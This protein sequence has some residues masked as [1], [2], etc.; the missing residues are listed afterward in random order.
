MARIWEERHRR[1]K[2]DTA[3]LRK[4][5][6]ALREA[7]SKLDQ[8]VKDLYESF[9]LGE[10]SKAEYIAAKAATIQKRDA[11]SKQLAEWVA[12]L[13]NISEDGKLDNQFVARFRPH[14]EAEIEEI[15][16][17]ILSDILREVHVYPGGR[18]EIIW[19]YREE[20]TKMIL[21]LEGESQN[22]TQESL[23]LLQSRTT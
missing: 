1:K 3:A 5:V 6:A 14:A 13:E 15:T 9:G 17:E 7:Y 8:Q 20:Y 23:D 2:R 22:G 21:E 10:I 11:T 16:Q 4:N 12:K 19:N 18:L